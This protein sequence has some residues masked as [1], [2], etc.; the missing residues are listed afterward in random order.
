MELT[1]MPNCLDYQVEEVCPFCGS[2]KNVFVG[3]GK[4]RY[5]KPCMMS[6]DPEE[7]FQAKAIGDFPEEM[8]L[9]LN[10]TITELQEAS[11]LVERLNRLLAIPES[12]FND[13]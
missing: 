13:A 12:E 10:Q 8:R 2:D 6:W 3:H 7:D 9:R 11:G 4:V 5:C 1:A